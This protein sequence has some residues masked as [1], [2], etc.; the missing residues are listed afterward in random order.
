VSNNLFFVLQTRYINKGNGLFP[1]LYGN[2]LTSGGFLSQLSNKIVSPPSISNVIYF[3]AE[4]YIL[5]IKE[6][7]SGQN[8]PNKNKELRKGPIG[9]IKRTHDLKF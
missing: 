1:N 4:A 6:V 3:V 5:G 2:R 8:H 7:K 9:M